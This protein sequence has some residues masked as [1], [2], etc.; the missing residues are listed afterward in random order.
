[1]NIKQAKEEIVD[2]V[3]AYLLKNEYEEYV[4]PES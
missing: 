2:T 3:Q 1:M 4:I